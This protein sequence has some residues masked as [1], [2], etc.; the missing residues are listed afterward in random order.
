MSSSSLVNCGFPASS[1][2]HLFAAAIRNISHAHPPAVSL[3]LVA[4]FIMVGAIMRKLHSIPLLVPHNNATKT[5]KARP[6][7]RT[8]LFLLVGLA[9][10]VLVTNTAFLAWAIS[11]RGT[12]NGTGTLYEASCDEMRKVNT[13]IHVLINILSTM[14]L[15][16]SNYC[17]QCLSA[18]SRPE[19]DAAH[20]QGRYLDI[21]VPSLHNVLASPLSFKKKICWWILAA[22][23]FPLH[24]W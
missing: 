20:A 6:K 17:M 4:D 1:A 22:S 8:S 14:L 9:A 3:R 10:A 21:G 18:P 2:V 5:R 7:W 13:G 16:G 12:R 23:S 11:T 19:V 15:G 24:L